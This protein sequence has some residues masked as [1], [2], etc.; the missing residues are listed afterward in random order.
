MEDEIIEFA[1]YIISESKTY[2]EAIETSQPRD[3]TQSAGK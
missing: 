3:R 2:R 1:D